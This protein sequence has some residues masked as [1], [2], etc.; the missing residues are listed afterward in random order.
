M[1]KG[2]ITTDC[3]WL[4]PDGSWYPCFEQSHRVEARAI[5]A[6]AGEPISGPDRTIFRDPERMLEERGWA[7][8]IPGG[9]LLFDDGFV[10]WGWNGKPT[11]QQSRA[12]LD[13]CLGDGRYRTRLP[14]ELEPDPPAENLP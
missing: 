14:A 4:G 8:L 10:S 3:G 13:W 12:L 1:G 5:L 7:K 9:G 11:P 2:K 6:A